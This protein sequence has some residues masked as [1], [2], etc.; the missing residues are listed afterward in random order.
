QIGLF[1]YC[2]RSLPNQKIRHYQGC[3]DFSAAEYRFDN[4][5]ELIAYYRLWQKPKIQ[6][7]IKVLVRVTA[8]FVESSL[9][10]KPTL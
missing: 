7:E 2:N 5:G 8:R 1:G 9:I 4:D 6:S 10:E 3:V